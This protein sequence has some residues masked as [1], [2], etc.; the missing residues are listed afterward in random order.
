MRRTD[1]F[2]QPHFG[3]DVS[4]HVNSALQS[5]RPHDQN[6]LPSFPFYFLTRFTLSK[7]FLQEWPRIRTGSARGRFGGGCAIISSKALRFCGGAV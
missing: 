5:R 7:G 4:A 6:S 2:A 3:N 1:G